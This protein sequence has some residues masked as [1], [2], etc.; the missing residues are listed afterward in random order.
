MSIMIVKITC[1]CWLTVGSWI[2]FVG[3]LNETCRWCKHV[4]IKN[5][6]CKNLQ[7][8]IVWPKSSVTETA[9]PKWPDRIGQIETAR[10]K[11]AQIET[12]RPNRPNRKVAWPENTRWNFY[13]KMAYAFDPW[14]TGLGAYKHMDDLQGGPKI[15]HIQK[16]ILQLALELSRP[17]IGER[18][19]TKK[20]R[21]QVL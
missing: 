13:Q 7:D 6:T 9:R 4:C 21:L 14:N 11:T 3:C 1:W 20:R 17:H 19:K 12:V 18:S 8:F 10:T 15:Q 5:G 2:L 16:K